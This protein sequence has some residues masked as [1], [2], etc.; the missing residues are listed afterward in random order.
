[1]TYL[2]QYL[3]NQHAFSNVLPGKFCS[4]LIEGRFGWY[5]QVN[6]ENFFVSI[7]QLFQAEKKIKCLS[8]IEKEIMFRANTLVSQPN[9]IQSEVGDDHGQTRNDLWLFEFFGNTD[10]DQFSESDA[11]VAYNVSGY[12]GRSISHRRKCGLC[13]ELLTMKDNHSSLEEQVMAN[14]TVLLLMAN[15]GGLAVPRQ[16]CFVMCSFAMQLYSE[17]SEDE[18]IRKKF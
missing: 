13:K 11:C 3:I 12:I 4:D 6:G 16:Y 1:M 14:P 8:L 18:Q 15:R 9:S 10:F 17:M 7:N 2:A 5:R